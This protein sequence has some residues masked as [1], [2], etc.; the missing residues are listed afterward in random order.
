LAVGLCNG[1]SPHQSAAKSSQQTPV[2]HV[3]FFVAMVFCFLY[4]DAWIFDS[5]KQKVFL[6]DGC[7]LN[8]AMASFVA[9][10]L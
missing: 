7:Q 3:V 6:K 9:P 5:L 10:L 2:H 1:G 8:A 4:R